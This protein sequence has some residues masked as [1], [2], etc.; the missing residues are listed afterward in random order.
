V[1]RCAT[2]RRPSRR[3]FLLIGARFQR[4]DGIN[5]SVVKI[6]VDYLHAPHARIHL[7]EYIAS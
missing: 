5:F 2:E 7:A 1:R 6:I 4:A 3:G